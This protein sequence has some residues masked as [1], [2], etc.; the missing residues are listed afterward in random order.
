[1]DEFPD[2]LTVLP[3]GEKS[4]QDVFLFARPVKLVQLK[5]IVDMMV[6]ALLALQ[7]QN[8]VHCDMKPSNLVLFRD[9]YGIPLWK[10]IDFDSA[11][12]HASLC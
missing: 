10:L 8:V 9:D 3:Q 4:L 1:V 2:G 6:D 5:V 12:L 7:Q 11:A